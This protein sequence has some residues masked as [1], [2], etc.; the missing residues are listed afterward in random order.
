MRSSTKALEE[1][2]QFQL[3]H[4]C[5][6]VHGGEEHLEPLLLHDTKPRRDGIKALLAGGGALEIPGCIG[7]SLDEEI[8]EWAKIA[9]SIGVCERLDVPSSITRLADNERGIATTHQLKGGECARGAPVAVDERM[10]VSKPCMKDCGAEHRV[11][12]GVI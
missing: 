11:F 12:R 9:R 5:E 4:L 1:V 8:E 2:V 3:D 10:N 7:G 6:Q